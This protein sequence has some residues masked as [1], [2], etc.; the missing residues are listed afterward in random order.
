MLYPLRAYFQDS[1]TRRIAWL[2]YTLSMVSALLA[3]AMLQSPPIVLE[4]GG[5]GDADFRYWAVADT[6][7]DNGKGNDNF[8]RDG[9]LSAG[10]G[11]S[12]LIKFGDLRRMIPTGK[13]VSRARLV[14]RQ[15]I[16]NA[17]DLAGIYQVQTPWGEGPGKRGAALLS[18]PIEAGAKSPNLSATWNSP[19]GGLRT[20]PWQAP[21]GKGLADR[22]EIREASAV[23]TENV[24]VVD[25]LGAT[26]QAMRD[27]PA[28]NHGFALEFRNVVDFRSSEANG[29]RPQLQI[30]LENV[31][32]APLGDLRVDFIASSADLSRARPKDGEMVTW[33]GN[34][35]YRGPS[36]TG[37]VRAIWLTEGRETVVEIPEGLKNGD[38]KALTLQ[39]PWRESLADPRLRTISLRAEMGNPDADRGNNTLE[40]LQSAIPV[41]LKYTNLDH[42]SV[43]LNATSFVNEVALSHSRFSFALDG[44][45]AGIR[46]QSI[47]SITAGSG[48]LSLRSAVKELLI[49]AGVP[50][51]SKVQIN[52]DQ[53]ADRLSFDPFPGITGGG[54]TRNEE[55]FP[56]V[57]GF[58]SEPWYDPASAELPFQI[59][60]LLSATEAAVLMARSKNA[61]VSLEDLTPKNTI[62]RV[63]DGGNQL[64]R[65][66]QM[67]F[68]PRQDGKFADNPA[69]IVPDTQGGII[70]IPNQGRTPF[71]DFGDGVLM[72]RVAK[73][74]ASATGFI[75]HWQLL[76]AFARGNNDAGIIPLRVALPAGK[77][78]ET[79]LAEGRLLTDSVDSLPNVIGALVDNSE[80]TNYTWSANREGWLEVDLQ[81]DRTISK[82]ELVS[83]TGKIWDKFRIT[84]YG[85][86]QRPTSARVWAQETAG[87]WMFKNR[88]N[89]KSLSYFGPLTQART[90]RIEIPAG[91]SEA[92]IAEIRIFGLD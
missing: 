36:E 91:Q 42:L 71:P 32:A 69:F 12:I 58:P 9:L 81:K 13:R 21:G 35:S 66:A 39:V 20:P 72:V 76:D 38:R 73:G 74:G 70:A 7:L 84:V 90:V 86:G 61:S 60:D 77:P 83:P 75:K 92:E 1:R 15:E 4:R 16:G 56:S 30:E 55:L 22:S 85:T 5:P 17:P 45:R 87:N 26:V 53:N 29:G 34:L 33:T 50:D 67:E 51:L 8:G 48:D 43:L 49:S 37:A 47:S 40:V 14:L 57:L 62:L 27:N 24:F 3:T 2:V 89:A 54:D 80:T 52:A 78:G 28:Q 6:F 44:V 18:V 68:Y 88:G 41:D 64:L 65:N 82:V 31:P 10:P 23:L 19:T 11:K 79:N 25:G 46:V 59:T 63:L